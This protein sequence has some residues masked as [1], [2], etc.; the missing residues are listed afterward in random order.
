MNAT[1]ELKLRCFDLPFRGNDASLCTRTST[2]VVW[3]SSDENMCNRIN[4]RA[5]VDSFRLIMINTH[6]LLTVFCFVWAERPVA[7]GDIQYYFIFL[8]HTRS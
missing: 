3:L 7:E 2:F 1:S 4:G 6:L 8:C 5:V